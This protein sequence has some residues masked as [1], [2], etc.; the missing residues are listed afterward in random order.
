MLSNLGYLCEKLNSI[1]NK[2]KRSYKLLKNEDEFFGPIGVQ[3]SIANYNQDDFLYIIYKVFDY[4]GSFG[5][6]NDSYKLSRHELSNVNIYIAESISILN[7]KC[8]YI[9]ELSSLNK[10]ISEYIEKSPR[11]FSGYRQIKDKTT[12]QSNISKSHDLLFLNKIEDNES[13]KTKQIWL[14]KKDD[15]RLF[16]EIKKFIEPIAG[17]IY[18]LYIGKIEA[19]YKILQ[20]NSTYYVLSK[21]VDNFN[22][23]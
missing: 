7:K 15:P 5:V 16:S 17:N 4:I 20:D 2:Y 18:R 21:K 9:E 8:I 12:N 6:K 10:S 11:G 3:S 19:K 14:A 23:D 1:I 22:A 13:Y